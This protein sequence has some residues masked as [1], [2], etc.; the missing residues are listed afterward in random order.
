LIVVVSRTDKRSLAV[1]IHVP[2]VVGVIVTRFTTSQHKCLHASIQDGLAFE[3]VP[4]NVL[5]LLSTTHPA[6]MTHR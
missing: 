6:A 4:S 3:D 2:V 1:R 5:F